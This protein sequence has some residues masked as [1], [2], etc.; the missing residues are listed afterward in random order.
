MRVVPPHSTS[1]LIQN[2]IS[3]F[4]AACLTSEKQETEIFETTTQVHADH[5]TRGMIRSFLQ[6]MSGTGAIFS[7]E[8]KGVRTY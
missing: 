1:K 2:Q 8:E 3:E 4:V 6:E 7:S 5:F